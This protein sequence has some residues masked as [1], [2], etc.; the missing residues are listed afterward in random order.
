MATTTLGLKHIKRIKEKLMP[1]YGSEW[2]RCLKGMK[3]KMQS[4]S[5][6]RNQIRDNPKYQENRYKMAIVYNAM[7]SLHKTEGTREPS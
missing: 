5:D 1:F 4:R 2:E 6:Y 7:M 3:D